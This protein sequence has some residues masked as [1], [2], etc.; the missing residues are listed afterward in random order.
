MY[1]SF[2]TRSLGAALDCVC[3]VM[4][5]VCCRYAEHLLFL[6][7]VTFVLL[8]FVYPRPTISQVLYE[9][10]FFFYQFMMY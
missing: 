7:R 9:L 5:Y 10:F 8:C 4:F 1:L 3:V 6:S 2:H